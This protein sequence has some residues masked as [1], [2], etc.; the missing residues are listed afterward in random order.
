MHSSFEFVA[1]VRGRSDFVSFACLQIAHFQDGQSV[2]SGVNP[3]QRV[4]DQNEN[5]LR[6][7]DVDFVA[8]GSEIRR[9]F[10]NCRGVCERAT[11]VTFLSLR[12]LDHSVL[13]IL[14]AGCDERGDSSPLNQIDFVL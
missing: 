3:I 9:H 2:E 7:R 1:Q 4:L 11:C 12:V 10:D 6:G 8:D 13:H 14:E 5:R